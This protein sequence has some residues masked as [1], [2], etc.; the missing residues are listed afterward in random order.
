[1]FSR[2]AFV[3]GLWLALLIDGLIG[4]PGWLPHPVILVGRTSQRLADFFRAKLPA[5]PMLAG[6]L[7]VGATLVLTLFAC[8]GLLLLLTLL[9]P[10]AAAIG[11]LLLLSTCLALRSLAEH[12]L[13]VYY[14]LTEEGIIAARQAVA[15]IVGRDTSRLDEQGIVRAC[16]ESV[17]E[18]MSDGV[19]APMFYAMLGSLLA[20][21]TGLDQYSLAGAATGAM[22]YKAVNTMDSM[23]GYKNEE[24]LLFGRAAARLD[25]AANFL[26]ARMTGLILAITF[27][28]LHPLAPSWLAG[29]AGCRH[30]WQILR[31][32]H[33]NHKSP[34]A[35]W[36]EAAMAG[37]LG[38]QLGGPSIYFG[39]RVEKPFLGNGLTAP[40]PDHIRAAVLWMA[41]ASLASGLVCTGVTFIC[42][43]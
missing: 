25:D 14:A 11:S 18:N 29:R 19:V 8:V 27:C 21:W 1:M 32:D 30:A 3:P 17:A 34:N 38:I 22:L 36:P 28:C 15:M 33:G 13:V 41:L 26:P 16:V 40:Q 31:R 9:S 43:I 4:D 37:I 35:G 5:V 24:F 23:F 12:A 39:H 7:T 6:L 2:L 20:V 10:W 42:V